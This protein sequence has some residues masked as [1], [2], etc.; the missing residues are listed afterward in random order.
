MQ[1]ILMV[2]EAIGLIVG[3]LA[4]AVLLCWFLWYS[5]RLVMHPEWGVSMVLMLLLLALAGELPKSQFLDITLTFVVVAAVPLWFAG[6]AWR[7]EGRQHFA[8]PPEQ[9][10]APSAGEAIAPT[11]TA[12]SPRLYPAITACICEERPPTRDEIRVVASRLW[13]EGF[14]QRFES[15]TIPVSFAARRT[16]VRAATAALSGQGVKSTPNAIGATHQNHAWNDV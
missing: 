10:G 12:V 2:V 15:Q 11:E 8:K 1:L 6:R 3:S 16:L 13:R 4:A 7:E 5:F 9:D 14:A